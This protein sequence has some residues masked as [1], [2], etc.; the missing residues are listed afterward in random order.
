MPLRPSLPQVKIPPMAFPLIPPDEWAKLALWRRAAIH[1]LAHPIA[2]LIVFV[3]LMAVI[4]FIYQF[5]YDRFGFLGLAVAIP[6][7]IFL[8]ARSSHRHF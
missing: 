4:R 6:A 8:L 3:L 2:F 7:V 1:V 5:S